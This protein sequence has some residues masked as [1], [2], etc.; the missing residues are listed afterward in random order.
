[1]SSVLNRTH[2]DC[3]RKPLAERVVKMLKLWKNKNSCD[4]IKATGNRKIKITGGR[5]NERRR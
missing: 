5:T 4:R 2:F 1:M 3:I